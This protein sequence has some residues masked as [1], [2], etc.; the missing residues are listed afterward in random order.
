MPLKLHRLIQH[1]RY[2]L[3]E[4]RIRVNKLE[5]HN[6]LYSSMETINLDTKHLTIEQSKILNEASRRCDLAERGML[7]EEKRKKIVIRAGNEIAVKTSTPEET[8]I[9]FLDTGFVAKPLPGIKRL[10]KK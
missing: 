2:I 1:M 10:E 4:A 8:Y 7:T 6:Y 9:T 3:S 5:I